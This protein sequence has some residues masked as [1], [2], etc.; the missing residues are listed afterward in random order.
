[1]S[2]QTR[3]AANKIIHGRNKLAAK[4]INKLLTRHQFTQSYVE[5]KSI[6]QILASIFET[7]LYPQGTH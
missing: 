7:P 2:P 1:M 4:I 6:N 5:R 3:D